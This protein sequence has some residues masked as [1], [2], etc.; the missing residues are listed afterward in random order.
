MEIFF[1]G[2]HE[3]IIELIYADKNRKTILVSSGQSDFLI[4][5]KLENT[6]I[7]SSIK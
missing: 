7:I 1:G 2:Y 5:I 4:I 6:V 3:N